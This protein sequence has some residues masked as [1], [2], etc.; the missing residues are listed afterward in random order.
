MKQILRIF[1][2]TVALVVG[3]SVAA[4]SANIGAT[5]MQDVEQ[6]PLVTLKTWQDSTLNE[7]STFI[8]G[9]VSLLEL[10]YKWQGKPLPVKKSLIGSWQKGLKDVTLSEIVKS[11][12]VY[13]AENPQDAEKNVMEVLWKL[14][15]H[16]KLTEGMIKD[17][18][19]RYK[20]LNEL[21]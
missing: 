13:A 14:Y 11:V 3:S 17:I 18:R 19:A 7:R 8:F 5:E 9:F 12:D 2:L 1:A 6:L 10:E 20:E 16:P 15:V 21:K 4:F